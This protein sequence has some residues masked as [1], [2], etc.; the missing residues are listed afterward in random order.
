MRANL[1]YISLPTDGVP[2][3][4]TPIKETVV[5]AVPLTVVMYLLATTGVVFT[6]ICFIFTVYFRKSK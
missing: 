2:H 5:L 3:D 1:H 6:F 4:G